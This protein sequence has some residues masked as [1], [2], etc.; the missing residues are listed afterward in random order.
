MEMSSFVCIPLRLST[1]RTV[2]ETLPIYRHFSTY[3]QKPMNQS[4]R[5]STMAYGAHASEI[6]HTAVFFAKL[7]FINYFTLGL[8]L[9][10]ALGPTSG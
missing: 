7:Y 9:P 5:S 6:D 1:N 4:S 3:A 8:P 10:S 2:Q